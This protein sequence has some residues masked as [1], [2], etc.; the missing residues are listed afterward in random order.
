MF[1]IFDNLIDAKVNNIELFH[2]LTDR[3]YYEIQ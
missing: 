3:I 2:N 1:T